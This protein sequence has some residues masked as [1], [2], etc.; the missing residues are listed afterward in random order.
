LDP[1]KKG[2]WWLSGN[3]PSTVANVEDVAAVISKDVVETKTSS[4]C[5]CSADE[6]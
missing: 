5:S 1:D 2:Q 6:H 3:V 4:A